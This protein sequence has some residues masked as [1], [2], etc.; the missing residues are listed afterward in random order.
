MNFDPELHIKFTIARTI[1]A[2]RINQPVMATAKTLFMMKKNG[3]VVDYK[4]DES[5]MLYTI[6]VD[7]VLELHSQIDFN[8]SFFEEQ[9]KP[10]SLS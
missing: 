4:L 5:T 2:K 9:P 1:L 10:S 6:L 8:E 7:K 3:W